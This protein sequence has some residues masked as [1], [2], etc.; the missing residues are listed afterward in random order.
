MFV[1]LFCSSVKGQRHR[2]TTECFHRG[3]THGGAGGDGGKGRR[4]GLLPK[5][6]TAVVSVHSA[7]LPG[8]FPAWTRT[9]CKHVRVKQLF[10]HQNPAS[11]VEESPAD[12]ELTARHSDSTRVV[13]SYFI[14]MSIHS[15][16]ICFGGL[17]AVN[18]IQFH[19]TFIPKTNSVQTVNPGHTVAYS[20][21]VRT[22]NVYPTIVCLF[23]FVFGFL[24]RHC[25]CPFNFILQQH[26]SQFTLCRRFSR[27]PSLSH[28]VTLSQNTYPCFCTVT[29]DYF[30]KLI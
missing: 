13:T 26:P 4:S 5:W 15:S 1:S 14:T 2:W 27:D 18:S 23:L 21:D 9:L 24:M 3:A 29:I 28:I 7:G 6:Q 25:T 22:H 30:V 20:S 17:H 12:G 11:V 19:T 10:S 16:R 8:K